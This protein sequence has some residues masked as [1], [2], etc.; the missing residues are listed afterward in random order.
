[1]AS[2]EDWYSLGDF[3]G[4]AVPLAARNEIRHN[5]ELQTEDDRKRALLCY[6]LHNV[7]M[8]SW[9]SVAGALYWREERR[10]LEAVKKFLTVSAG[11]GCGYKSAV[12]AKC[13]DERE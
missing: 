2:V 8:A 13:I 10:A 3:Y 7:P 6:Y 1:M 9:Q 4:L 12:C 11:K 5:P